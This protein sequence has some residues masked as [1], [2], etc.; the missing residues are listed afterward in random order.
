MPNISTSFSIFFLL[1]FWQFDFF[2]LNFSTTVDILTL[3]STFDFILNF[4][5]LFFLTFQL[6]S[7]NFNFIL[8]ISTLLWTFQ[9]CSQHFTFILKMQNYKKILPLSLFSY[10]RP[11]YSSIVDGVTSTQTQWSVA[12]LSFYKTQITNLFR[13]FCCHSNDVYPLKIMKK[14]NLKPLMAEVKPE[15]KANVC[16]HL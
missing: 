3:F 2:L 1:Y 15:W 11:Q 16:I 14:R 9:L 12:V 5:T 8:D 6:Y 4:S 13:S 10:D 7:Q